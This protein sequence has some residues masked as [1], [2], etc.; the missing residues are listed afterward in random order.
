M[1]DEEGRNSG[2]ENEEIANKKWEYEEEE[3][4]IHEKINNMKQGKINRKEEEKEAE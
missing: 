3:V 1:R 4:I 2:R